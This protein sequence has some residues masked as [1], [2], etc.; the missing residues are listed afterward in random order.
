MVVVP[1]RVS[2]HSVLE[3]DVQPDHELKLLLPAVGDRL[4]IMVEPELAVTVKGAVPEAGSDPG[5]ARW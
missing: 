4:K 5:W 2:V 3:T 1:E